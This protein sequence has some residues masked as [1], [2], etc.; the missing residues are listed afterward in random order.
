MLHEYIEDVATTVNVA[1]MTDATHA[2]LLSQPVL[3]LLGEVETAV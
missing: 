2:A 1:S 3:R